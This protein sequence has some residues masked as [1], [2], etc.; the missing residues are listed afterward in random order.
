MGD[1]SQTEAVIRQD[2]FFDCLYALLQHEKKIVRAE[3]CWI[4]S[5]IAAGNTEQVD[6]LLC[7]DDIV[8]ELLKLFESDANDVKR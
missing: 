4:I 5:N 2:N 6:Q 1:H 3:T 7:R 8:G